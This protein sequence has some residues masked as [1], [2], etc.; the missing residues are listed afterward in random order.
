M[1]A[2]DPQLDWYAGLNGQSYDEFIAS[3][4]AAQEQQA[5]SDAAQAQRHEGLRQYWADNP[6]STSSTGTEFLIQNPRTPEEIARANEYATNT[7]S[8]REFSNYSDVGDAYERSGRD[9]VASLDPYAQQMSADGTANRQ[10]RATNISNQTNA[11]N[12]ATAGNAGML[13]GQRAQTAA[14]GMRDDAALSGLRGAQST[15]R[16]ME[17]QNVGDLRALN[18]G[19]SQLQAGDYVGDVVSNPG[20]VGMQMDSYDQLGGWASGANDV[21]SDPGLV[22][23][24]QGVYDGYGGFANGEYD[25]TSQAATAV[26]DP[27]ALAAQ[28]EAL[29]EFRERMDP[30][31]TAQEQYLF[32]QARLQ[33]EQS[34]RANRDANYRE[35]ERRGMGGST[36]ALSNL[37]AS[38]AEAGNTR[39][40]ADTGAAAKAVDRAEKAL[41]N[42]GNM[43]SVI[44]DQSF[45]RDFSTKSAADK[46]AI[47]NNQQRLAGLEG[48]G[49]MSTAM[50]N[51]D[52]SMRNSNANR[53]LEGTKA[54]G[55]M[56]TDM[57]NADD[58]IQMNNQNQRGIQSRH[59][60]DF[61]AQQQRDA[62]GRGTDI[63]TAGFRQS[64]NISRDAGVLSDQELRASDSAYNRV[65]N[66]TRTGAQMNR[67]YVDGYDQLTGRSNESMR[68]TGAETGRE[69]EF[70]LGTARINQESQDR[71][72]A[73]RARQLDSDA[74]DRRATAATT[75]AQRLQADQQEF[76]GSFSQRGVLGYV[77]LT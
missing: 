10:T 35:L 20:L 69:A 22:G 29:G 15:A 68:D 28:K 31:L 40:L 61:A 14:S 50:R 9:A 43:G 4:Q 47:N 76:D 51:A 63:S 3:Q 6:A 32:M 70:A 54:Q 66:D 12:S 23:M 17:A 8:G 13:Q 7:Q 72:T 21:S 57:R 56:A 53:Q 26:A 73:A 60:D 48:Q 44:A 65:A 55:A 25:L 33:R 71:G 64:E 11:F 30:K 58:A 5:A 77:G 1:A 46:M 39:A 52:D 62:W 42:Y 37:N 75:A 59:Q 41:V 74:E 16:G 45:Q 18:S 27:E 2:Y 67:D 19:M 24:Q 49:Q 36:M 38:S 34:D